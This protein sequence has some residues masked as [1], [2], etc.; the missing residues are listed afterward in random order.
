MNSH[1]TDRISSA[2]IDEPSSE[3]RSDR[4]DGAVRNAKTRS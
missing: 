2:I 1:A 3:T 4:K